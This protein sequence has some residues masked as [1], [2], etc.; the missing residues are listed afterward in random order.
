MMEPQNLGC[1]LSDFYFARMAV[2]KA[3]LNPVDATL[4]NP[5]VE[6]IETVLGYRAP[7]EIFTGREN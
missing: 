5:D 4:S 3:K 1:M 2:D 6:G 7:I